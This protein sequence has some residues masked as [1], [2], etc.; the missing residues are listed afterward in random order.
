MFQRN[1]GL[2][3]NK[4]WKVATEE[5]FPYNNGAVI[6]LVLAQEFGNGNKLINNATLKV[7]KAY[8]LS[9]R[10]HHVSA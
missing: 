5:T 9:P 3:K 10:R 2:P 4:I 7:G 8:R 6:S 1:A